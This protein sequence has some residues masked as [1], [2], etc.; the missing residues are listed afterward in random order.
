MFV[1][2]KL[3]GVG[4]GGV[5]EEGDINE[6]IVQDVFTHSAYTTCSEFFFHLSRLPKII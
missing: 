5:G 6:E 4:G 2:L 1:E 3:R